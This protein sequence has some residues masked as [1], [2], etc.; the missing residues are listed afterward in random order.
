[1]VLHGTSM[2]IS[3]AWEFEKWEDKDH[4]AKLGGGDYFCDIR[5]SILTSEIISLTPHT[6]FRIDAWLVNLI[7]EVVIT[8]GSRS[9]PKGIL[10]LLLPL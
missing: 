10:A 4:K 6:E 3:Y 1:M 9:S 7:Y 8:C 5:D 2:S